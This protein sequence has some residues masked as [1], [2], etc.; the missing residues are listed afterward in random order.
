MSNCGLI[1]AKIR[2]SEKDL[3]VQAINNYVT[4]F[5][6]HGTEQLELTPEE[7]EKAQVFAQFLA[8]FFLFFRCKF[9]LNL[10]EN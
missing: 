8:S 4:P 9:P 2:A 6:G 3:P 10:R 1:D 5:L 7:R